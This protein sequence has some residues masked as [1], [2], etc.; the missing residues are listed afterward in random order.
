M[1]MLLHF[2]VIFF[3]NTIKKYVYFFH[4]FFKCGNDY[5][6]PCQWWHTCLGMPSPNVG[7]MLTIPPPLC[8]QFKF[9]RLATHPL[10]QPGLV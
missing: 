10:S 2:A 6:A 9:H 3:N 5:A 7:F 8:K 4:F 1:I